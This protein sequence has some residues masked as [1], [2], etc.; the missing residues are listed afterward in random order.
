M[1]NTEELPTKQPPDVPGAANIGQQG[2][3]GRGMAVLMRKSLA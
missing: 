1:P 2:Q 3:T